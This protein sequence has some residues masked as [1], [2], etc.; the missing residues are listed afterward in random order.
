MEKK[1]T[2]DVS[3]FGLTKEQITYVR[4]VFNN[5]DIKNLFSESSIFVAKD[6]NEEFLLSN[7]SNEMQRVMLSL[8]LYGKMRKIESGKHRSFAS[9]M[10]GE[11]N[12]SE[13]VMYVVKK[14][15]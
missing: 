4:N 1:S 11:S 3:N 8:I 2:N 7:P 6:E 12:Y 10:N 14:S 13:T 5:P 9:M 15:A